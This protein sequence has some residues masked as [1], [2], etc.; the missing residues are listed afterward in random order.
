MV[1]NGRSPSQT[2]LILLLALVVLVAAVIL[3]APQRAFEQTAAKS[4]AG[5]LANGL[6]L[7]KT[8]AT[9]F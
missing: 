4:Y 5:L 8:L 7:G 3:I 2:L 1:V 6:Q 9:D